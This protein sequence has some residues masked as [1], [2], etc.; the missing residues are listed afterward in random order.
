MKIFLTLHCITQWGQKVVVCRSGQSD[1]C[2]AEL[3]CSAP[4]MWIGEIPDSF[5]HYSYRIVEG[6]RIVAQESANAH[7]LPS[8]N[9][10]G[11]ELKIIDFWNS[12]ITPS[13]LQ[14]SGFKKSFFAQ[15]KAAE[16]TISVD[17]NILNLRVESLFLPREQG[18]AIVGGNDILGNWSVNRAMEF[19]PVEYGEWWLS[20]PCELLGVASE[21]KLVVFDRETYSIVKWE[22]GPNREG[23]IFDSTKTIIQNL[24][25]SSLQPF[26][27]SSGVAVPIFSLRSNQNYGVGDFSSL[28]ILVD[29]A[30]FTGQK[31][32][33]I[34]PINDTVSNHTWRDS[35]PY[36]A[37]SIY[38]LHPIYLGL[39]EYPLRDE[40][41]NTNYRELGDALNALS[42]VD[43]EQVIA[44]KSAYL[45]DLFVEIA[46]EVFDCQGFQSFVFE[47]EEWL[48][49]YA[50]FCYLRDL[51]GSPKYKNWKQFSKYDRLELKNWVATDSQIQDGIN[52]IYFV[53]YL[54]DKQL[55]E[56]RDYAHSKGVILKGDIPIGVNPNGVDAW[57]DP[58]L[59]NMD[60]QTGAPPDDFAVLGQNWGFP[61]YNWDEMAKDGY[62][63]WKK[64][65]SKMA[66]YFDAY[67]IDHILGFFR[68]WEIPL[69]A[70]HGLLGHFS[71]ALP[72]S[73]DEIESYGFCFDEAEHTVALL[74]EKQAAEF[75]GEAESSVFDQF[76]RKENG[77]CSLNEEFSTQR[78]I[79]DYFETKTD[80]VEQ[81]VKDKLLLFCDEV[82]FVK[83]KRQSGKYHPR[84]TAYLSKR[85]SSLD[86]QQ[87][88]CFMHLYEDFYFHRH[89]EFWKTESL[90]KLPELLHSTGM[91]ACGE[92]LGM[93]P[94]CVPDVMQDLDI[95]SLE[96]ERMPKT[97]NVAFEP[98]RNIPYLSVCT[99][100]THDMSPIRLWWT[101]D[102]EIRQRYFNQILWKNGLAP[103]V[104]STELCR[105]ILVNHLNSPAML[106]IL[107]LQDW[108]SIDE[109]WCKRPAEEERINVPADSN[110]YW[111]YRMHWTLEKLLECADTNQ[112]I[113][114][115]IRNSARTL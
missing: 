49:P 110:H 98:L 33:Q 64:R 89:N 94:A 54:L 24:D 81:D 72:M 16:S 66:D 76:I 78:L 71:P 111:Q 99:T 92:D 39:N 35:Y 31:V 74:S 109:S 12:Q 95:L 106:V 15:Q 43:Y 40:A 59:Y 90:K 45:D 96:I 20:L 11:G 26:F 86:S 105:Q 30:N 87:Q 10:V 38:A 8:I 2:V 55:S 27:K 63:W 85:F 1:C 46:A 102:A 17:K 79:L 67:R 48:F 77:I 97:S 23:F 107:P 19:I 61:T 83:D 115:L 44:L 75:F 100:S 84:I 28:K 114:S 42:V 70:I 5:T 50:C 93:I 36:N 112:A 58:A 62:A 65:F 103:S 37:I 80:V 91:L 113:K 73:K 60:T 51:Y 29:W 68:I 21:Y 104:C 22:K 4:N 3:F 101:E 9:S 108:L 57:T 88:N 34:L 53:Q 25:A 69:S 6:D 47:N 56:V 18:L 14:T 41:K 7:S 52:K 13:F 32:I 82:L